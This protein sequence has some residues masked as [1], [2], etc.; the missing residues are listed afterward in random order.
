MNDSPE[1]DHARLGPLRQ[2]GSGGQGKVFE[3][4]DKADGSVYKEYSPRVIDDLDVDAL[5]RFT[6][7]AKRLDEPAKIALLGRTAWPQVIVRRD[8]VVRGF[9]MRRVPWGYTAELRFGPE[10]TRELA[11]VQFLLNHA[12][13]LRERGLHVS[14]GFRLEFLRDT[15]ETLALFH[16]LGISVGDLSPNNLLFSLTDRPR[17]FFIDCDT[18]CLHGDSVLPQVETPD[19]QAGGG[20]PG[21]PASDA[22]KFGL[23][24]VRLFAGDQ[25]TK[26]PE[27]VPVGLRTPVLASLSANPDRRPAT[28]DWLKL[29]EQ[30]LWRSWRTGTSQRVG[31]AE[32]ETASAGPQPG[33]AMHSWPRAPV[34]VAPPLPRRASW[35]WLWLVIPLLILG[36]FSLKTLS[37]TS[38]VD[39]PQ[40]PTTPRPTLPQG[41]PPTITLPTNITLPSIPLP[42]IPRTLPSIPVGPRVTGPAP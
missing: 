17:C 35:A 28:A 37:D 13:Y 25:Q 22:Y 36:G 9:L 15:A 32:P 33:A 23:L 42:S 8:G 6:R 12:A 4:L 2:I 31:D 30:Q 1:I 14:D 7:F 34:V 5:R 16:R 24:V 39:G 38:S 40:T 26:D 19:W 29:L 11:Q 21:T 3:L 18:M 10:V 20:E 41:D 27:A